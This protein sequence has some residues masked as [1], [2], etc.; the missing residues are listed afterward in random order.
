MRAQIVGAIQ[1]QYAASKEI[2]GNFP[3]KL[4][5]QEDNGFPCK[6]RLIKVGDGDKSE[7]DSMNC[8]HTVRYQQQRDQ[9]TIYDLRRA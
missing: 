2:E 9:L 5:K 4:T 7:S 1:Q 6:V 3:S 8:N